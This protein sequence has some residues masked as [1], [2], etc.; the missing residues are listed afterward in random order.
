MI[1]TSL[2]ATNITILI[3]DDS[4]EDRATYIRYLRS[5]TSR[6][7]SF[8]EAST[9]ADGI[10]LWRS[11]H[12]DIVLIDYFLPDGEGWELLAAMGEGDLVPKLDAIILTGLDGD[13]QP[14]LQT[15]RL[16]AADYLIKG[17][18]TSISLCTRVGQVHDHI[19]L[20]RQLQRSQEQEFLVNKISLHIRQY[21]SLTEI[22]NAIVQE[23]RS[24]LKADRTVVYR[25]N[26]D[27]SGLVV[28]E[29]VLPPWKSCLD[30]RID[31]FCFQGNLG[32]KYL[33]G[34]IF[35][36]SNIHEANLTECHLQLMEYF[37]VRANLVLPILIINDKTPKLWGLLIV[38]QCSNPRIWQQSDINLLQQLS[39]QL[40]I[41]LQQAELYRDL[42][43]SN[44]KLEN[45]FAESTA[46]LSQRQNALQESN[47]R[48]QSLL[49][50]VR[51][52]VVGLSCQGQVEYVN[53]Y[54]LEATG[55]TLEEVIGKDWFTNF[56]PH[57]DRVQD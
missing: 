15:M 35:A 37:Q 29:A 38:H 51:L 50:N 18:I 22:L 8:L 27:F 32:R 45:R 48:W 17:E 44:A 39:V 14:I 54:F 6:C 4:I 13:E 52:I 3:V 56:L 46:K 19:I 40:A 12:P 7:Y 11:Q 34:R 55:Y 20:T 23:V 36:T 26:P 31:E 9:L 21:V 42:Q 28:A 16:G 53:P 33:D 47:R 1:S 25:F 5:D 41:A 10:D 30:Q 24:F 57:I 43:I 49:D 2:S